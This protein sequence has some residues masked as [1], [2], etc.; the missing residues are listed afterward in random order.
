MRRV[1]SVLIG[2]KGSSGNKRKM[3]GRRGAGDGGWIEGYNQGNLWFVVAKS[4][5]QIRSKVRKIMAQRRGTDRQ[6]RRLL[7]M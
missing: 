2:G 5:T 6:M 4:L 3:H 1:I 7:G